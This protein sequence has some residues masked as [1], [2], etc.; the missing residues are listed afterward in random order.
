[1]VSML[2]TKPRNRARFAAAMIAAGLIAVTGSALQAGAVVG[3]AGPVTVTLSNG[4][5]TTTAGAFGPISGSMT[6]TVDAAGNLTFPQAGTTFPAF[7]ITTS[8]GVAVGITPVAA[9]AFTG[10]IDTDTGAVVLSGQLTT[11]LKVDPLLATACPLGPIA[12]SFRTSEPGGVPYNPATGTATLG[13]DDF[14]I[15][16]IDLAAP[17]CGPAGAA[18][19]NAQLTLPNANADHSLKIVQTMT[20]SPILDTPVGENAPNAIADTATTNKGTAV[21]I[22]VLANDV[23]NASLAI[24]PASLAVTVSAANGPVV[25]SSGKITYTPNPGFQGSEP[26]TYRVCSV[27]AGQDPA[28]P[29]TA[30]QVALNCDS[31]VVT[32]TVVDPT[33]AQ[34]T[35]TTTAAPAAAAATQLPVTGAGSKPLAAIGFVALGAGA[36]MVLRSR[37]RERFARH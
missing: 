12:I 26:F 8:T 37:G 36:A 32:V 34:A 33:V 17:D 23:K 19:L 16:A 18:I 3:P 31:A 28:V 21:V 35:T 25:V 27:I 1:M 14:A 15:P 22:D 9:S 24:D 6:G 10:T 13:D 2:G 20:F 11:L 29:L 30:A 4:T 7:G 5:L